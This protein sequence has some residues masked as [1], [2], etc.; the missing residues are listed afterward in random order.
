MY[1][2][3][4][5]IKEW[6]E[7]DRFSSCPMLEDLL[8]TGNPLFEAVEPDKFISE[9]TRR[10]P[11]LKKLEGEPVPEGGPAEEEENTEKEQ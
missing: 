10:L 5:L 11:N 9:V 1:I 2:S 3:N 8:F 7:F 6:K 4:N